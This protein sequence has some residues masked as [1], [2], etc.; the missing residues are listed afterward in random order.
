M[1][2]GLHRRVGAR[3]FTPR[4]CRLLHLLHDELGRLIGP[5]LAPAAGAGPV[6]L[7]P[8]L[9]QT[10]ALLL[11]GESEK[12]IAARLGLRPLTVHKYIS[13]LYRKYG[14]TSRAELL[15]HFIPRR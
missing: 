14:V 11:Q 12:S 8:R 5:T 3:D 6:S 2:A 13:E 10:L 4:E 1:T 9:R 7:S 15:A